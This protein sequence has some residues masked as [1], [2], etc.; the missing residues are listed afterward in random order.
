MPARIPGRTWLAR[1]RDAVDGCSLTALLLYRN[2]DH[3]AL[4][5]RSQEPKQGDVAALGPARNLRHGSNGLRRV[6]PSSLPKSVRSG[7]RMCRLRPP[8]G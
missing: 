8:Q 2:A 1:V 7:S 5:G 6:T 3:A 4:P